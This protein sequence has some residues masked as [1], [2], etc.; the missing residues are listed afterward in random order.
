MQPR[1]LA[2]QRA[3]LRAAQQARAARHHHR[4]AIE[5]SQ[6]H[7]RVQRV[8]ARAEPAPPDYARLRR[9]ARH[10]CGVACPRIRAHEM[11]GGRHAG[12][13]RPADPQ[14]HV[15]E[16]PA[17]QRLRRRARPGAQRRGAGHGLGLADGP[18]VPDPR[19]RA[20]DR[21]D[22]RLLDRP[23]RAR[24]RYAAHP[25]RHARGRGRIPAAL[26]PGQDD[27]DARRDQPRPADRRHRRGLVRLGAP[28]VRPAVPPDRR[29]HA[30]A[31]G[32][33]PHPARHVERRARHVPRQAFPGR[34]RGLRAQA[35][36][37]ASP[38]AADRR[39]RREGHA[40][41]HRA[42]RAA[43]QPGLGRG[44]GGAA[45]A[46]PAARALRAPR[47]RLLR[48]HQDPSHADPFCR[49]PCR[50]RAPHARALPG[51]RD[52]EGFPRA[53]ADR[54][55]RAGRRA[56]ARVRRCGRGLLR[57]E[58]LRPRPARAAAGTDGGG[59]AALGIQP[60]AAEAR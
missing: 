18:P 35:R 34:G 33:D 47:H 32:V 5:R 17:R 22:P 53:H 15:P 41:P 45:R 2:R 39:Q 36:A 21:S 26:G 7:L 30:A 12:P 27:R 23:G 54:H 49:R 31:R 42:V 58:L 38:A 55:A 13:L 3:A 14:L 6:E 1:S 11:E 25:A 9:A 10:A 24:R 56:A 59:R 43:P 8:P 51:G 44:R 37:E 28:R 48:D 57:H 20:R 4:L 29:A 19:G 60:A 46:R 52:R 50:C 40:A 16:P